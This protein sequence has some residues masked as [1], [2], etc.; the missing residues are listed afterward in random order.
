MA[1][2]GFPRL[3]HLQLRHFL[4]GAS[5]ALQVHV[6]FLVLPS[7]SMIQCSDSTTTAVSGDRSPWPV[8]VSQPLPLKRTSG[9]DSAKAP[10]QYSIVAFARAHCWRS[11]KYVGQRKLPLAPFILNT[12]NRTMSTNFSILLSASPCSTRPDPT[13][14]ETI[15]RLDSS[16][17]AREAS[18][19]RLRRP[20]NRCCPFAR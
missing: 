20:R 17:P 18:L 8:S 3:A 12:A 7:G 15:V 10:C 11:E 6:S 4:V 9:I 1:T 14:L 16:T 5:L 13:R 2:Q 19:L